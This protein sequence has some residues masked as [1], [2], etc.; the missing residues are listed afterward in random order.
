MKAFRV[1]AIFVV[2]GLLI[3]GAF[4]F[5]R[6]RE[7]LAAAPAARPG[8]NAAEAAADPMVGE[9]EGAGL[10]NPRLRVNHMGVRVICGQ[11]NARPALYAGGHLY[12]AADR[13][14]EEFINMWEHWCSP[15]ATEPV[16]SASTPGSSSAAGG[17]KARA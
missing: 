4:G 14:P 3:G 12:S 11:A 13:E 17:A 10:Q 2:M 15:A 6:Y 8:A 9:A 7:G 1:L 5:A 16:E